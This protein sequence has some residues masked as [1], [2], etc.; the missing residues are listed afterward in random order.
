MAG[1]AIKIGDLEDSH[2]DKIIFHVLN[3]LLYIDF[4]QGSGRNAEMELG[5]V[6]RE[7]FQRL[8]MEAERQAEREAARGG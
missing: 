4:V 2:G 6:E 8:F 3:D 7:R 5:S 1:E